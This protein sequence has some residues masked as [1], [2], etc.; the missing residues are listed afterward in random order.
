MEYTVS[1]LARIS[2]V[3][4]RTLRY[5]DEIGLLKPKRVNSN[6]YRIYGKVQVDLLQQILF[7]RELGISLEEIRKIINSPEFDIQNS[8]KDHL[9]FLK[10][11]KERIESLI[12]NVNKTIRSM[13]GEA[14]MSDKEKFEGFK[15]DLIEKNEEKYGKEVR[16]K[17]EDE[18]VGASNAKLAG[19]SE[20][21]WE[22]HQSLTNELNGKLKAA[23]EIGDPK[24]DL[25]QEVC[26]LH[27]QW[28]CMFWPDGSYSKEGHKALGQ[29]Y[30]EDHRFKAYYDKIAEGAAE[31]LYE[32]LKIYCK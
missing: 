19:M 16:E 31:F 18:A 2:G 9:I 25:A 11:E 13:K 29:M 10:K 21:Q 20:E 22:R 17:Y 24:S 23:M 7:Y 5:Y 4:S 12:E 26:D 28:L 27:R 3:S 1:K 15:R 30:V 14:I 8:L 6:G 32:A